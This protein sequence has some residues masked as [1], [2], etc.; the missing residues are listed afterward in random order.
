M[1]GNS[2]GSLRR[3]ISLSAVIFPCG[4]FLSEAV[5]DDASASRK[6]KA[7]FALR[8]VIFLL[9]PLGK[10]STKLTKE[11]LFVKNITSV[12]HRLRYRPLSSFAHS[13]RKI[14]SPHRGKQENERVKC[15]RRQVFE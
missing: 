4:K 12:V 8:Q 5:G 15:V 1:R 6:A 11:V 14:H 9:S 13:F 7:I 2:D 3:T 10:V